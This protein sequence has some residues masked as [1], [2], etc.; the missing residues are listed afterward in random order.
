[1]KYKN[2]CISKLNNDNKGKKTC[3]LT[4]RFSKLTSN[5]KNANVAFGTW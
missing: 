1:M 4:V 2:C 3:N 5:K